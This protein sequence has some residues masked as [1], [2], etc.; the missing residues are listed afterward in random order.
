MLQIALTLDKDAGQACKKAGSSHLLLQSQALVSQLDDTQECLWA[1]DKLLWLL[2]ATSNTEGGFKPKQSQFS[3]EGAVMYIPGIGVYRGWYD[4]VEYSNINSDVEYNNHYHEYLQ[5]IQDFSWIENEHG[6]KGLG[7]FQQS[8]ST[9]SNSTRVSEP[10]LNHSLYF[11]PCS[12]RT[13][14]WTLTFDEDDNID[15]FTSGA[16]SHETI[17]EQVMDDCVGEHKQFEVRTAREER[18]GPNFLVVVGG[19]CCTKL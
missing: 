2:R 17:C 9:W 10:W 4:I 8:I 14:E 11:D 1:S 7:I 13:R 15:F 5:S 16:Y 3:E 12:A 18:G 19:T 6:D